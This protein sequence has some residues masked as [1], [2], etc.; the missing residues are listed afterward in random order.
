MISS[1]I[2]RSID[3]RRLIDTRR[4]S[5]QRPRGIP[6]SP[7]QAEPAVVRNAARRFRDRVA[8]IR[9]EA[10]ARVRR[11]ASAVDDIQTQFESRLSEIESSAAAAR[12]QLNAYQA[13]GEQRSNELV[14]ASEAA[15]ASI[16]NARAEIEDSL[17]GMSE[18]FDSAQDRRTERFGELENAKRAEFD[19]QVDAWAVGWAEKLKELEDEADRWR[20][21]I[22]ALLLQAE[23][24][25]GTSAAAAVYGAAD[26]EARRQQKSAEILRIASVV[27]LALAVGAGLWLIFEM[28]PSSDPTL[29]EIL[30]F[31]ST[32]ASIVGVIG[33]IGIYCGRESGRHRSREAM[34]RR[35]AMNIAAF[36]PFLAELPVDERNAEI[37]LA[38][39][40][41][42]RV[43]GTNGTEVAEAGSD[44][45]PSAGVGGIPDD[46]Q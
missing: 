32:R 37:R 22:E 13:M 11:A 2:G 18:R 25:L 21:G 44:E 34:A 28:P 41:F 10:E 6:P 39:R 3:C 45:A 14:A 17:G 23:K 9:R 31:I 7:W 19:S 8:A 40:S 16:D 24:V 42:F 29:S 26:E 30:V 15:A 43:T 35:D 38:G 33:Y 4:H 1:R 46:E 20:A 27:F 5:S 36:R 12:E